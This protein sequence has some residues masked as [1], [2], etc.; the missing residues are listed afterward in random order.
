MLKKLNQS[1]SLEEVVK[2]DKIFARWGG[3]NPPHFYFIGQ[4]KE[5][6]EVKMVNE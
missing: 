4:S 2:I 6:Y 1:V 3:D 5:D